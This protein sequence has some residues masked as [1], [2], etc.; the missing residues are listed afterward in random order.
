MPVAPDSPLDGARLRYLFVTVQDLPRTTA[1]YRDALGLA[2]EYEVPGHVVFLRFGDA[3]QSLALHAGRTDP[4]LA[5]DLTEHWFS[6]LDVTDL[7]ATVAALRAR[8][9]PVGEPFDV[10]YGRAVKL[11]DPEGNVLELHEPEAPP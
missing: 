6:V 7:D 9:V 4:P 10:P 8:G 3:G 1:F 5:G 11:R 2:V